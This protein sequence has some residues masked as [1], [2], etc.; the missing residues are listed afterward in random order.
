MHPSSDA[1]TYQPVIII[2]II[3]DLGLIVCWNTLIQNCTG[4][5]P[6]SSSPLI[7]SD[8]HETV[9]VIDVKIVREREREREK[10]RERERY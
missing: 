9:D 5:T 2:N 10:E 6:I 7:D 3:V 1:Y 4:W 8:P